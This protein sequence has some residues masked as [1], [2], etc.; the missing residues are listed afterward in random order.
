MRSAMRPYLETDTHSKNGEAPGYTVR[1]IYYDTSRIQCYYEKVEGIKT[2]KKFRIR[3]YNAQATGS[4]VYLEIKRKHIDFIAKD[5][6]P[7][8]YSELPELFTERNIDDHILSYGDNGAEKESARHF[9]YHYFCHRLRPIVLITYD[10]E[11]YFSKFDDSLR[12]TID[13][14]LRSSM[15]PKL[16]DLFD[17]SQAIS[18]MRKH[19][20]LEVKFFGGL[21]AWVLALI[22]KYS[23]Q[24]M[25]ISKYAICLESHGISKERRSRLNAVPYLDTPVKHHI[26]GLS[27]V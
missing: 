9:L 13:K 1:S 16:D 8:M 17:E 10:R 20:V 3:G 2:R 19:V 24:R 21:P 22:E 12:I 6:A 7:L 18:A 11:A 4:V 26:T 5:R 25:A 27:R 14:N 23:L 15:F